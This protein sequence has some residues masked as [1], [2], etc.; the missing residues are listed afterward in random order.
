MTAF[1][2]AAALSVVEPLPGER[3]Y[4][5][6]TFYGEEQPYVT[7]PARNLA[8]CSYCNPCAPFFVSTAGRYVWSEC[9]FTFAW[10]NG[11]L[12]VTSE[13]GSVKPA[14]AGSS[15][16]TAYLAACRRHFAPSGRHPEPVFFEKP[17]FNT[18]VESCAVGNGQTFV[19]AYVR[20]IVASRIP[21]GV[22]MIDDGWAPK[23]RYGDLE[24]D[25]TRFPDPRAMFAKCRA[26]GFRT[27]LWTTP[28]INKECRFYAEAANDGL[29]LAN[30]TTGRPYDGMYYW[31]LPA[32][33]ILDILNAR[34]R[35]VLEVRYKAFASSFGFDGYKFDFTDAECILRKPDRSVPG[36]PRLGD[37]TPADYTG[38]WGRF[39]MRFP[40]HEMRAGWKF[41][42]L[43][44]VCRLQDKSHTWEDLRKVVP[45]VLA[46]GLL[47]CPFVC[48]D[49]VGGGCG[50][51]GFATGKGL[52]R[53][54][55]LRSCAAQAMMPMMQFSAAPWRL[56]DDEGLAICRDLANL[57][58]RLAPYIMELATHA[59]RTGEPIVRTM[60]YVFP[61][62]GLEDCRSQFML[63]DR[64][65]VA[66]VTTPDDAVTVRLPDG[67]WSDDLGVVH[68]GPKTLKL[69]AVPLLRLPRYRRAGF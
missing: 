54:L 69:S 14:A 49:M 4:G 3:W 20:G 61:G 7:T 17:Q 25:K 23:R 41:G 28:Y 67:R 62:A 8:V 56:L 21:C 68:F 63:G 13:H 33:G 45:D 29:L 51:D 10:T 32:A 9:P 65:L 43:P 59:A 55:F 36:R 2:V 48:P 42:G 5:G 53:K 39:A 16:K 15:L 11:V 38:A 64:W 18:W 6:T 34:A 44:L 35:D 52:D 37:A 58:C 1:L 19:E 66:P 12:Y 47:G 31:G 60:S 27:I 24:F 26:A 22:L 57:H 30:D 40:F 46:A 50:G